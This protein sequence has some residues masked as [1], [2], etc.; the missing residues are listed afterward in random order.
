MRDRKRLRETLAGITAFTPEAEWNEGMDAVMI[1]PSK[2]E[3]L[4]SS[5]FQETM[6]LTTIDTQDVRFYSEEL[7]NH[8]RRQCEERMRRYLATAR[9]SRSGT[10][11]KTRLGNR[12]QRFKS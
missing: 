12:S 8:V 10:S 4:S 9:R 7:P 1:T 5:A 2:P 6:K 11:S 3:V